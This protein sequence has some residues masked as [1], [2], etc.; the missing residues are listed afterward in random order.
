MGLR[1]PKMDIGEC[2]FNQKKFLWVV[3]Y[4]GPHEYVINSIHRASDGDLTVF[5]QCQCCEGT[6]TKHYYADIGLTSL[7]VPK[8][9]IPQDG[10][11]WFR[12]DENGDLERAA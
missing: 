5:F 11:H 9:K 10:Q 7:G 1:V 3:D 2:P 8:D 6:I 12:F 4:E